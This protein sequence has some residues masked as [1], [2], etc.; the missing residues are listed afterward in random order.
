ML[1]DYF[2]QGE[3]RLYL[4]DAGSRAAALPCSDEFARLSRVCAKFSSSVAG[5]LLS[6]GGMQPWK[7]QCSASILWSCLQ[8]QAP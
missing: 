3:T 7:I 1:V 4:T 6:S 5:L 8:G 2:F